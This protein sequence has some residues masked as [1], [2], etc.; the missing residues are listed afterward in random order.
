[1]RQVPE[2]FV[3]ETPRQRL[4][5]FLAG[6]FPHLSRSHLKRLIALGAVRVGG[7]L[8]DADRRLHVGEAV[9]VE[10]PAPEW[11]EPYGRFSD[12]VLHEDRALLVLNK[13]A[14]LLMHPLGASW[15]AAPEAALCETEPNLAGILL[16]QRPGISAAGTPR[17]GIVHRLD[18]CTSGVLLVA[19]T[20]A[21][22]EALIGEFKDREVS[23]TYRAVVRGQWLEKRASVEAPV[24]RKPGHRR[25]IATPFGKEAS[26]GFS[27]LESC[28]A[29]AWVEALPL[30]GRTHQI[31]VHLDLLGHPVMGD[32][33]FDRP[34]SGEPVPPRLMLHAYKIEFAHP[35]TARPVRFL[36]RVPE[37]MRRFWAACRKA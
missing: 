24:G 9:A 7:E 11:A 30:T 37:D 5:L 36:A 29:G 13:P 1:M 12:W 14:G 25:I 28:A 4:D 18:R 23:K 33:E 17:C 32:Q 26:T 19:K 6:H 16:R 35:A 21:A 22:S 27:V 3:A 15:L 31:R 8:A 20:P 34:R 10:F 2:S